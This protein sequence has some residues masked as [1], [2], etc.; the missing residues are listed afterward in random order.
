SPAALE[1]WHGDRRPE[2]PAPRRAHRHHLALLFADA[3]SLFRDHGGSDR[4]DRGAAPR[5][6]FRAPR[7]DRRAPPR[8]LSGPIRWAQLRA[9]PAPLLLLRAGLTP[10][11]PTLRGSLRADRD[12]DALC[13]SSGRRR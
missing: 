8:G 9:L 6:R 11:R 2:R 10:R 1:P 13:T 12:R 7:P 5:S 3:E 4:L